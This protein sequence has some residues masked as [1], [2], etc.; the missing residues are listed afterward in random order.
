MSNQK[1]KCGNCDVIESPKIFS[2]HNYD[3]RYLCKTCGTLCKDC[4]TRSL[5]SYGKCKGCGDQ[6]EKQAWRGSRWG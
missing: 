5:L 1:F 2:D 6:A 4:Y 3:Q